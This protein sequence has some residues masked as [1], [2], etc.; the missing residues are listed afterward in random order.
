MRFAEDSQKPS[1]QPA[2]LP[3]DADA[4]AGQ[5]FDSAQQPESQSLPRQLQEQPSRLPVEV[6]L[7]L[8]RAGGIYTTDVLEYTTGGGESGSGEGDSSEPVARGL[9][10]GNIAVTS[11]A[12]GGGNGDKR[13]IVLRLLA[14]PEGPL[15]THFAVQLGSQE[16]S[17]G[18]GG[19]QG[20]NRDLGARVVPI[21][22]SN[23]GW[24]GL[25]GL[26]AGVS[27]SLAVP[28]LPPGLLPCPQTFCPALPC[29]PGSTAWSPLRRPCRWRC[30]CLPW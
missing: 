29:P 18:G 4:E 16:V 3:A 27:C 15:S 23:S 25:G 12:R 20:N 17:P 24:A 2:R 1:P 8:L 13:A 22:G 11:E 30:M 19:G 5:L 28:L 14:E 9:T 7:G 26:S 6:N 21:W 10:L